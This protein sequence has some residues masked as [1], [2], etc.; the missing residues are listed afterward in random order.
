MLYGDIKNA[1]E[2]RSGGGNMVIRKGVIMLFLVNLMGCSMFQDKETL[3]KID[4]ALLITQSA[5]EGVQRNVSMTD[6]TRNKVETSIETI[7]TAKRTLEELKKSEEN[8][9]VVD[10]QLILNF[11]LAVGGIYFLGKP[12][13]LPIKQKNEKQQ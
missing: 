11:L 5:L 1:V 9:P 6:E 12:L 10:W 8:K 2:G 3:E 13:T 7:K 4:K